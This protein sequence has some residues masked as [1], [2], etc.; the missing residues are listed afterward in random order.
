MAEFR[1]TETEM[2]HSHSWASSVRTTSGH[3]ARCPTDNSPIF[4][5][6]WLLFKCRDRSCAL[7]HYGR[8]Y[9]VGR[10]FRENAVDP[11]SV[12]IKMQEVLPASQCPNLTPPA[13][14][15]EYLLTDRILDI[16]Q[17]NISRQWSAPPK[18]NYKFGENAERYPRTWRPESQEAPASS[19]GFIR[20]LWKVE[21]HKLINLCHV[22]PIRAELELKHWTRTYFVDNFVSGTSSK[23][24]CRSVPLMCFLDGFGIY[25]NMNRSLMGIYLLLANLATTERIRQPNVLP[26]T[27]GPH[28]S[29]LSDV[30]KALQHMTALD[31]GVVMSI[32]GQSVFV[33]AF[34]HCFIG[35]MP[36][37]QENSGFKSQNAKLGCKS[38]LIPSAERSNLDFDILTNGRTHHQAMSMRAELERTAA[39]NKG[40]AEAYAIKFGLSIE[41]PPLTALAPALDII[42]SR[43]SDPAHSEFQGITKQ[44]HFLLIERVLAAPAIK[45]YCHELRTLAFPPGYASLQNPAKHLGS[46]S[47]S[48]HARWSMIVPILLRLWLRPEH[49]HLRYLRSMKGSK[50]W[51]DRQCV[52]CVVGFFA[53]LA[54]SNSLLMGPTIAME[55]RDAC[56]QIIKGCRKQM[57]QLLDF[58]SLTLASDGRSRSRLHSQS[59]ASQA[60]K[61][62]AVSVQ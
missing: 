4:P 58:A 61:S 43:P 44:M 12:T 55:A 18:M 21:Q 1:S 28:G 24:L 31:A 39:V 49:M 2:W 29:R 27:L 33:C 59:P 10:D 20:R 35:D 38:C 7:R 57:Q 22:P 15:G 47:L 62:T 32:S 53:A 52:D 50:G 17:H 8:V 3:Y 26:V 54:R 16:G 30:V 13:S 36:Q 40:Q 25:R 37:Q 9:A 11:G 60:G 6:D 19:G 51:T 46:Y 23:P 34:V 42:L 14:P 5:S 48:D 56:E 41:Q 45:L